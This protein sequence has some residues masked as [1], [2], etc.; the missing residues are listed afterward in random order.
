MEKIRV[1]FLDIDGV[2]NNFYSPQETQIDEFRVEYLKRIIDATGAKV[3]LTSSLRKSWNTKDFS[4]TPTASDLRKKQNELFGKYGI[5]IYGITP[6]DSGD[7]QECIYAWLKMH[8]EVESF[9]VIDD[10]TITCKDFIGTKLI[11]TS[12]LED[13]EMIRDPR[14]CAGLQEYQVEEAIQILGRKKL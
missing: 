9:V 1:I 7:T 4:L 5:K 2:L 8:P 14:D 11:K 10:E 12:Y 13:G 6:L 3:V